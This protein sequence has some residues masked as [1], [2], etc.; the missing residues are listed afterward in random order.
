MA[1]GTPLRDESS[2]PVYLGVVFTHPWPSQDQWD[3]QRAHHEED[4][5]LLVVP[6]DQDLDRH[7]GTPNFL[8]LGASG[9]RVAP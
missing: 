5:L 1:L 6:Q 3:M 2:A 8:Q 9:C 4:N 7:G